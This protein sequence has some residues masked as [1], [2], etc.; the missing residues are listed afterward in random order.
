MKNSIT[1]GCRC[2]LALYEAINDIAT[3]QGSTKQE[4]ILGL[5]QGFVDTHVNK[6]GESN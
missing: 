2:P 3:K 4:I 1:I 6:A 5:I